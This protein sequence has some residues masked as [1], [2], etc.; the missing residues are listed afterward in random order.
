MR[1]AKE[2]KKKK[3]IGYRNLETDKAEETINTGELRK[4]TC[5]STHQDKIAKNREVW[6]EGKWAFLYEEQTFQGG[7]YGEERVYFQEGITD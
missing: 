5:P 3:R 7:N 6:T 1:K 2:K 4:V